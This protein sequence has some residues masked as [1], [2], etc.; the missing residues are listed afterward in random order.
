[1]PAK[2][3][4]ND[5]PNVKS[6]STKSSIWFNFFVMQEDIEGLGLASPICVL[7]VEFQKQLHISCASVVMQKEY[8]IR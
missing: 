8:G 5:K 3:V 4:E 7:S 1:M 6:N 2:P